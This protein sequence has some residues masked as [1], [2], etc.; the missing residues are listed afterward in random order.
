MTVATALRSVRKSAIRRVQVASA[1]VS[2]GTATA[3]LATAA[4]AGNKLLA[5]N[6]TTAASPTTPSGWTLDK[7]VAVGS[8]KLS[9]YRLDASGGETS[10]L[11]APTASTN[12]VLLIEYAGLTSGG[13]DQSPTGT[14]G[15]PITTLAGPSLTSVQAAATDAL[16]LAGVG[17]S[18]T[19]GTLSWS[20]GFFNLTAPNR[21]AVAELPTPIGGTF[22]TTLSWVNAASAGALLCSYKAGAV[23]PF[24]LSDPTTLPTTATLLA[25]TLVAVTGN[26]WTDNLGTADRTFDARLWTANPTTPPAV[27]TDSYPFRLGNSVVPARNHL[28]GGKIA[29]ATSTA[30][31]WQQLKT[32]TD[33]SGQK[34]YDGTGA[35][36]QVSDYWIADGVRIKNTMDGI[37][38]GSSATNFRIS[39]CYMKDIRDDAIEDDG[40]IGGLV[41]DCLVEGAFNFLSQQQASGH[42]D[43]VNH[44]KIQNTL[45]KITEQAYADGDG[46]GCYG[47]FKYQNSG[48][49]PLI[50]T[51]CVFWVPAHGVGSDASMDFPNLAVYTRVVLIWGGGGTYPGWLPSTGVTVSTDTTIW[52]R[53]IADWKTRHAVTDFDTVTMATLIAPSAPPQ[54]TTFI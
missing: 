13:P 48:P 31:T 40:L 21:L 12:R 39:N 15:T 5:F 25:G 22:S 3:T 52:D 8:G 7:Q 2:S 28:V 46:L 23:V 29:L 24:T 51:D 18:A 19:P 6:Y 54:A 26:T 34:I 38:P 42:W 32:T 50:C 44:L 20:A 1:T 47:L 30:L 43:G 41:D 27:Y 45:V 16:L 17:L 9:L 14:T 53:A 49:V 37:R 10:I 11:C 4:T 35:S 36:M 33:G